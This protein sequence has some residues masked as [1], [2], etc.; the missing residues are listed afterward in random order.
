MK[1]MKTQ[2]TCLMIFSIIITVS[3]CTAGPVKSKAAACPKAKASADTRGETDNSDLVL[4]QSQ[5]AIVVKGLI[6]KEVADS[7]LLL[8]QMKVI[9]KAAEEDKQVQDTLKSVA[10]KVKGSSTRDSHVDQKQQ[11]MED[12][13][14]AQ[15]MQK[16]DLKNMDQILVDVKTVQ[17]LLKKQKNGITEKSKTDAKKVLQDLQTLAKKKE[18]A[19]QKRVKK[20]KIIKKK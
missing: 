10:E 18:T 19:M 15:S 16:A 14:Q 13:I 8:T 7:L 5:R 12:D 9:L 6:D 17:K 4:Q 11:R 2:L 20:T 3:V 1:K